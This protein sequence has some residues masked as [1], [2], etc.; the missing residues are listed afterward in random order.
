MISSADVFYLAG[1]Q[2]PGYIFFLNPLLQSHVTKKLNKF[3]LRLLSMEK[4]K[5]DLWTYFQ[6]II[7][8]IASHSHSSQ[9]FVDF[10]ES[11]G[12]AVCPVPLP[13]PL[14]ALGHPSWPLNVD[15]EASPALKGCK[16]IR[17]PTHS[18]T[19]P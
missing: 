6:M 13:L 18:S 5:L 14:S 15:R 11:N 4:C 12:L 3:R 16:Y 19:L 17:S 2:C 1:R 9:L 8:K 7:L 10:S